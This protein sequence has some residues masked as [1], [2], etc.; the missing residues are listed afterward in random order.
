MNEE[1]LKQEYANL[2]KEHLELQN[3]HIELHIELEKQKVK[4]TH[5]LTLILRK[6]KEIER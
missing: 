1:Y 4:H 6:L 3:K 5:D 2:L